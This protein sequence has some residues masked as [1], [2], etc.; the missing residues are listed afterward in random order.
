M[1]G[2][3]CCSC[4]IFI[5]TLYSFYTQFMLILIL[6]IDIQYL[7]NVVFSFEKGSNAQNHS[8]LGF[9]HQKKRSPSKIPHFPQL[10][11]SPHALTLF[12]K[13]Y[14]AIRYCPFQLPCQTKF[15]GFVL[16]SKILLINQNAAFLKV[17][18]FMKEFKH[19]AN[20]LMW[21]ATHRNNQLRL[22]WRSWTCPKYFKMINQL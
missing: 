8:S 1:F 19:K 15:L 2:C 16:L 13:L 14:I 21:I 9:Q 7:Q 6:Y 12:G 20:F 3:S 10:G 18:D 17:Q 4:T 11:D 5:L 22:V